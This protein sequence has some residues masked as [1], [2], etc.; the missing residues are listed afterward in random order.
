MA[1]NK[2]QISLNFAGGVDTKTDPKQVLPTKL[3]ELENAV[4]TR[5]GELRKRSGYDILRTT[6]DNS[7]DTISQA[8]GVAAFRD[9]LNLFTGS[10]LYTY[11]EAVESWKERGTVSSILT[12]ARSIVR[13]VYQQSDPD[14]SYSSGLGTYLWTDSSGGVRY[15]V[16]D[17]ESGAFV[18]S[19]VLLNASGQQARTVAVG[20][21]VYILYVVGTSIRFRYFTVT[22]PTVLSAEET[23]T[24][25]LDPT[26]KIYDVQRVGDRAYVSY[27]T[28]VVGGSI[29]TFYITA[30]RAVSSE[31]EQTGVEASRGIS[32]TS[33]QDDNIFVSWCDTT[34]ARYKVYDYDLN[35]TVQATTVLETIGN[36][37]NITSALTAEDTVT[38]LYEVANTVGAL[39]ANFVKRNTGTNAGVVGTPSVL[40]RSVGL[41]SKLFEYNDNFYVATTN[42]SPLQS[43]YFVYNLNGDIATKLSTNLGGGY[44]ASSILPTAVLSETGKFIIPVQKKGELQAEESVLYTSLGISA[45]TLDFES[46]NNFV[47]A[48][49][50]QQLHIVGGVLQSYD[51]VTVNETGFSLFPETV[52]SS[53]VNV[54]SG[55][56]P[57]GTYQY[58]VV[59]AW[60]D[61]AGQ[62]HRSAPSIPLEVVVSGG[63]SNVQLTIPTLRI[64]KKEN[65]FLEVYRTEDVG[66]LFYK[67]TSNTSLT[68][69]NK[70]VDTIAYTDNKTDAQL[71]SGE[72][73]YTTGGVLDNIAPPS[74]SM[75]V[76]WKN[77]LVIKSSD[78]E[79]VLWFSKLRNEGYPV[80]FS[81]FNTITVDPR[82]G[83]ISA[84]G[85]LD[86]KLIIFKQ[87]SIHVQ[88]GD[89]PNNLGEQSDFGLPQLITSD[90]GCIDVNSVVE[91]PEGLMFKS[92]KGIYMLNRGLSLSYIGAPVEAYNGSRVTSAELVQDANQVRFILEDSLC[93]VYDYFYDQWSTFTNHAGVGAAN[94]QS[95]FAF[96]KADGTVFVE[97]K[98]KYTDGANSVPMRIV[99]SW[100]KLADF[101]G[102][103]RLYKFLLLGEYRSK[104]RLRVKLGYDFNSVFTQQVII[105]PAATVDLSA[106]GDDSPY[107]TGSPYGGKY[108]L[109]QWRFFPKQQKCQAV[110]ICFEDIMDD[111]NGESFRI[112]GLR[113]EMG[114]KQGSNKLATNRSAAVE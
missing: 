112:S 41:A 42:K 82:G 6:I 78:D 69:N 48:E 67:V 22:T 15:S 33:D 28:N 10:K 11:L 95:K 98:D 34:G 30:T 65:V 71:I 88:Q 92:K 29:A 18:V 13:N 105:D 17:E 90:A 63:P 61:N 50:G 66:S 14:A 32:I 43:T 44:T 3:M 84:L 16:V 79:N 59:Y 24:T 20:N 27:N 46:L 12:S 70:T 101:Q 91:T 100:F 113:M 57:N 114:T 97:N 110:R 4:F 40:F 49:L 23:L 87:N 37:R 38:F 52:S 31:I 72:L 64:T 21:F 1:L 89:G 36:L 5:Q 75:I 51:G 25:N 68:L 81:D 102:F 39:D 54:G 58:S 2:Q 83:D 9:E 94:Y 73:L 103:Q 80:E 7:S 106:Y 99:T 53:L 104:H 86:D 19:N 62:I 8:T 107:G 45:F 74:A 55:N 109:Y 47:T 108:P 96:V 77:R 26:D 60:I 35:A 56:I 76:T 111:V 85:V 93:L